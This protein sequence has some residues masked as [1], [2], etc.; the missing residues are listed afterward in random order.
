MSKAPSYCEHGVVSRRQGNLF[1]YQGWPSVAR[2]EAGVLYAVSSA[3]RCSHI[4]PFGKTALYISKNG[5]RTWSPPIVVND[6]PLDDRDAGILY[7]GGGR[8]LVTWFCHPASVYLTD[9]Y[10]DIL[11]RAPAAVRAA[12]KGMLDDYKNIPPEQAGGGSFLR[13]SEDR[14]MTWGDTVRLPVSAPHGPSLCRDGSIIY[15]GKEL[16]ARPGEELPGAIAAYLSEDGGRTW[17]RRGTCEKPAELSWEHFHEPHV[18][19]LEDGTL[20]GV[21][22]GQG[23]G[24]PHGFSVYQTLSH[25]RGATWS[26]WRCLEVSGS[27]PHLL[28][29]SSGAIV[30]TFGRREPP[31]GERAIVSRDGGR[32]WPEEYILDERTPDA[33]L[34]YPASVELED[35]S[36]LTVYYQKYHDAA[37]DRFDD[38]TSVLFT[39]WRP[40]GTGGAAGR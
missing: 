25:D 29:H 24:I 39:R 10:E 30:C 35:G 26:P 17:T 18:L 33:D 40:D 31:Y 15:L 4:C 14:G 27:P 13:I 19:E 23:E 38:Q 9:Y 11:G 5:G 20:L 2:D 12:A 7:L 16:Y 32:T 28:R 6:T 8:L 34:G 3:F 1:C 36:I 21:I 22:R 37:A